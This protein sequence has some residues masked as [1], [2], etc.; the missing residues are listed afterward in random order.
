MQSDMHWSSSSCAA[1]T[2]RSSSLVVGVAMVAPGM[3]AGAGVVAAVEEV[4]EV[5]VVAPLSPSGLFPESQAT[6]S[7]HHGVQEA[8][9]CIAASQCVRRC[10]RLIEEPLG[11][12]RDSWRWKLGGGLH[13][14]WRGVC[15]YERVIRSKSLLLII[16]D[17]CPAI[18]LGPLSSFNFESCK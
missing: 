15:R 16:V 10:F 5:V 4:V 2:T 3:A 13:P 12:E 14:R 7:W 9:D 8:Q 6:P 17:L 18:T 11:S 1:T